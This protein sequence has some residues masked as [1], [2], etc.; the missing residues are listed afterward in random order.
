M[1][2]K[3]NQQEVD[4][5]TSAIGVIGSVIGA[6]VALVK[7]LAQSFEPI[8]RL[9]KPEGAATLRKMAQIAV[10]D[11]KGIIALTT[12]RVADCFANRDIFYQPD[13]DIAR[14]LPATLPVLPAGTPKRA[15][16]TED[17]T[18]RQMAERELGVSGKS[19]QELMKLL[20]EQGKT[21]S[22]KQI[23]EAITRHEAGDKSDNLLANGWANFFFVEGESGA[24]FVVNVLRNAGYWRVF[25]DRFGYGDRWYAG[26]YVF[27]RN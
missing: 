13:G 11:W 20:V 9:T 22:L 2:K 24:V 21:C 10:E 12:Y 3:R 4:E 15:I 14:W 23:D 1:A 18:F 26:R 16:T 6:I 8:Y 17:Q 7:E 25:I 5:L 19:D 27:F